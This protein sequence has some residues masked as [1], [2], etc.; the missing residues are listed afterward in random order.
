MVVG[1]SSPEP[2][3]A[4]KLLEFLRWYAQERVNPGLQDERRSLSPAVVLDLASA[5]LFGLQVPQEYDGL[6][7]THRDTYRVMTQ[8]AAVDPNLFLVIAVHN[9]LGITPVHH[10]ATDIVKQAVLPPAAR[11]ERLVTSAI[12][13]PGMGS[14][15]KAISTTAHRAP[16][17]G[18]V[19]NGAKAFISLGGWARHVNVFCRLVDERGQAAGTVGLVADTRSPGF[20]VG[21]EMMTLGMRAFPQNHLSFANLAVPASHLLGEEGKGLDAAKTAFTAGRGYLAAG[22]LGAMK[23]SLQMAHRFA[24]GRRVATGLLADNGKTQQILAGAIAATRSVELLVSHLAELLD[25][26]LPVDQSL[27]LTA[28]ALGCELMWYVLDRCV[29]MLGGRGFLDSNVLGQFFRDYRVF[30]IFEG[31]TETLAQYQ[32]VRFLAAPG[33]LLAMIERDFHTSPTLTDL[34][35][36]ADAL[37]RSVTVSERHRHVL[38]DATGNLAAWSVLAALTAAE[39]KQTSLPQ[40]IMAAEWCEHGLRQQLHG[41][42]SAVAQGCDLP[43]SG[44]IAHLIDSYRDTIGDIEHNA[45][46]EHHGLD[47]LLGRFR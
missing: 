15:L 25:S 24:A 41:A 46:G 40:D 22:G 17:G 12:T 33:E 3:Q 44:E 28:K 21:P 7:L 37:G 34:V 9:S 6:G 31:A 43:T 13:E 16:G 26:A 39:A 42:R 35:A 38:A 19:V 36:E 5:G 20:E 11:G 27:P 18:Y 2:D 29:Q 30:R 23:R 47:P 45:A 10:S 4:R 32:G 8:L 1:A 14:N